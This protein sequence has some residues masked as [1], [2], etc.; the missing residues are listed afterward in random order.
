MLEP[1]DKKEIENMIKLETSKTY[2]KRVGDTPNDVLQLVP[3]K[4]TDLAAATPDRPASVIS[5]LSQQFF[6]LT[7]GYPWFFNP[8]SSVWV[9]GTGSIVGTNL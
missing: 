2:N 7:D 8:N 4:Y 5:V 1:Q 3:K 9:S 6:N